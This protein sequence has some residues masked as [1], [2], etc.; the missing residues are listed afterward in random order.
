MNKI[1][2]ID[3][4]N[5][6]FNDVR[7]KREGFLS[8]LY[9]N[10]FKYTLWIEKG[11]LYFIKKNNCY[12]IIRKSDAVNNLF[13]ITTDIESLQ[14][15]LEAVLPQ[16]SF[17]VMIDLVGDTRVESLKQLFLDNGFVEYEYIYRMCRVGSP[18]YK[19][20]H[21]DIV[22]AIDSDADD[23]YTLLCNNFDFL[24][25][26]IIEREELDKFISEKCVLLYKQ[27]N[28]VCGFIIFE[29][30]GYTLYLRYWFVSPEY[31]NLHIGSKL[32]NAFMYQG[33]ETK[34]QMFWVL[35]NN[36]NAIKRYKHYGFKEEKMYDYV[37][38]L[39]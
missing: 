4:L 33:R 24:S 30:N 12:F 31:R 21:A 2:S 19:E 38:K 6:Y 29:L 22:F 5:C 27:D 37:L 17:R 8:N 28:K 13:Y 10:H 20:P 25:E 15:G 14:D 3:E 11:E 39:N 16:I 9:M 26:Q 1:E 35:A 7:Q 18:C 23:V 36:K 32:F 34:R